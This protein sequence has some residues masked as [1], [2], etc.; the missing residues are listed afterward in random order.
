MRF[1]CPSK[2]VR[3]IFEKLQ[4]EMQGEI[5]VRLNEIKDQVLVNFDIEVQ[6]RLKMAKEQTSAFIN[7][8]EHIFWELTHC[9]SIFISQCIK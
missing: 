8:Y 9:F 4:H 5:D 7:R 1:Y 6:E 2:G 3:G